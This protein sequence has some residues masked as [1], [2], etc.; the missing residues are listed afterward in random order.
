MFHILFGPMGLG[1]T[2]T[3]FFSSIFS[4]LGHFKETRDILPEFCFAWWFP[5]WYFGHCHCADEFANKKGGPIFR[6]TPFMF[7]DTW[8]WI[9]VFVFL[10]L[11]FGSGM[12]R[13]KR[14][15]GYIAAKPNVSLFWG[16]CGPR[17][18]S[19]ICSL[20]CANCFDMFE[21]ELLDLDHW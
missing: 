4:V 3:I 17:G 6:G 20:P 11:D 15:W 8:F 5:L 10:G 21:L 1:E 12:L 18:N 19:S 14:N 7:V 2:L 16:A 9:W 13:I